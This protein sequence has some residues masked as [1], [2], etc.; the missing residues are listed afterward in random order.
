MEGETLNGVVSFKKEGRK[1]TSTH[2]HRHQDH[3]SSSKNKRNLLQM[4]TH[5]ADYHPTHLVSISIALA[6]S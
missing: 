5:H 3:C 1:G 4:I 2:H 6:S